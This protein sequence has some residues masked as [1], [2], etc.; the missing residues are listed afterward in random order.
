R[1]YRPIT[2]GPCPCTTGIRPRPPRAVPPALVLTAYVPT[3]SRHPLL[4]HSLSA[5][6]MARKTT[7]CR[8]H[9][10]CRDPLRSGT[11]RPHP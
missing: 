9:R 10:R 1:R 4:R 3:F 2:S 6:T 5:V 8:R 11:R 7:I